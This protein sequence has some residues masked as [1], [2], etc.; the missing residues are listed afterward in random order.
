MTA[1]M[2]QTTTAAWAGAQIPRGVWTPPRRAGMLLPWL[3]QHNRML[4][5]IATKTPQPP[6]QR[7]R[8]L[9]RMVAH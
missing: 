3:R 5:P 1:E 2:C 6:W 4:L 7:R 9:N 8:A